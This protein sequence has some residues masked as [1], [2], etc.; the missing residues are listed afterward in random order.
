M[1]ASCFE[2]SLVRPLAEPFSV[3]TGTMVRLPR[4]VAVKD[5][6]YLGR[7]KGLSLTA[8][9]TAAGLCALGLAA[10]A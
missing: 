3:P 5:G 9:S 7:P 8:A 6:P 10:A 4:T 1:L 2:H